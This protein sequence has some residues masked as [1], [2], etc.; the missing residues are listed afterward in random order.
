MTLAL[1]PGLFTARTWRMPVA[2]PAR[3]HDAALGGTDNYVLDRE[4]LAA[5]EEAAPGFTDLLRATRAWHV[6]VV[7]HLAGRG[8]DQFLDLAGGLPRTRENTHQVAQRYNR[9]AKVVYTNT[10]PLLLSYARALLDDNEATHIVHGD[11]LDPHRLLDSEQLC[12]ALDLG[13]PVAVL[14]PGGVQHE[15]DDH[16]LSA[17]LAGYRSLLAPGSVLALSG[18]AAPAD[19][20]GLP[21]AIERIWHTHSRRRVRCRT[22]P[23]LQRLFDGYDLLDPGVL[24]VRDWWPDGP[25][26]HPPGMA[27]RLGYGGVGITA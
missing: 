9:D 22:V 4:A 15:L 2:S 26:L 20:R 23:E 19:D 11:H 1:P 27:M 24:P 17:A 21:G 14:M 10:N 12:S 16:R 13:R 8:I 18:W 3:I 6:R 25:L 5:L 7:R